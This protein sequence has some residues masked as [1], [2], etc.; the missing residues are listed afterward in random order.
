MGRIL[1]VKVVKIERF[2]SEGEVEEE[3]DDNGPDCD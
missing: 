3:E 2:I 1:N